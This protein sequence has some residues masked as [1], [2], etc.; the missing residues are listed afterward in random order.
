VDIEE[1][2]RDFPPKDNLRLEFISY[3]NEIMQGL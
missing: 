3:S 1:M 2:L